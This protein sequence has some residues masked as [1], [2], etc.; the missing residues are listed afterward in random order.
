MVIAW[1][2]RTQAR[3]AVMRTLPWLGAAKRITIV[4]VDE[5]S[6]TQDC[7]EVLRLL[8]D[9][10]ISA[11]VRNVQPTKASTLP[12]GYFLRLR[13]LLLIPSSWVPFVSVRFLNGC[14]VV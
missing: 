12:C 4:T 3:K 7:K 8:E 1:K 5:P 11:E 10:G 2:P 6:T 9:H 14:S 13:R